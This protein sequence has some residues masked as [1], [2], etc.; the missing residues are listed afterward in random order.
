[1][2]RERYG[3]IGMRD[4]C[5]YIKDPGRYFQNIPDLTERLDMTEELIEESITGR[6]SRQRDADSAASQTPKGE[7]VFPRGG[8][9]LIVY[10]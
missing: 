4:G 10:N 6:V 5:F 9:A 7:R 1:M 8:G 3:A 2:T